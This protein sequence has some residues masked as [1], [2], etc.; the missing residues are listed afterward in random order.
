MQGTF[1]GIRDGFLPERS[2]P[3]RI[4]VPVSSKPCELR[5]SSAPGGPLSAGPVRV[6]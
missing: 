4:G 3:P 6:E 5:C 1:S 2:Q